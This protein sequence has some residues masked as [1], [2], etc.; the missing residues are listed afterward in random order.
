[1]SLAAPTQP[2]AD[3]LPRSGHRGVWSAARRERLCKLWPHGTLQDIADALGASPTAVKA[4]GRRLG[5]PLKTRTKRY[6]AEELA[7]MRRLWG[8]GWSASRIGAEFKVSRNAIIGVAAR[9]KFGPH[10]RAPSPPTSPKPPKVAPWRPSVARVSRPVASRPAGPFGQ[11]ASDAA[12]Q[13]LARASTLATLERAGLWQ[14]PRSGGV[15][16]LA[17]QPHHCRWPCGEPADLATFRFC[18]EP[19]APEMSPSYCAAH[20]LAARPRSAA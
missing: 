12:M 5:L 10:A 15:A 2:V 20:A 18:G 13:A 14:A 19:V 4:E 6:S 8:L 9:E 16:L 7:E 3:T 11:K 17:A 1:M